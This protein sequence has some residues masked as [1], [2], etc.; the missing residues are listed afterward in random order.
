MGGDFAFTQAMIK[1][2]LALRQSRREQTM[3]ETLTKGEQ[4]VRGVPS[5]CRE[6]SAESRD[7]IDPALRAD[8]N[9]SDNEGRS[10][11]SPPPENWTDDENCKDD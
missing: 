7:G 9:P 10:L 5:P 1:R 4:C 8:L 11:V 2:R 6:K 3:P